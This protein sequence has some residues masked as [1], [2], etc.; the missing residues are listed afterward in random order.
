MINL[1]NVSDNEILAMAEKIKQKRLNVLK[2]ESFQQAKQ[3]ILRWDVPSGKFD[4][5]YIG[6]NIPKDIV[7]SFV[8]EYFKDKDNANSN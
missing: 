6:I 3:I 8:T 4:Y 2:L 5:G 7:D 1:T